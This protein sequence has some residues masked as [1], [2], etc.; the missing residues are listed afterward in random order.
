[1]NVFARLIGL[2]LWAL[3][4]GFIARHKGR[5]FWGWYFLSFLISP[6]LSMIITLFLSN[7]L[8]NSNTEQSC[9]TGA[10]SVSTVRNQFTIAGKCVCN[11]CGEKLLE[12]SAFCHQCG[13]RYVSAKE[14][15]SSREDGV[16]PDK[17]AVDRS[18][19]YAICPHCGTRQLSNRSLCWN[20]GVTFE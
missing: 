16:L 5:S 3:I 9:G 20:C 6:L 11:Q 7:K 2:A 19:E 8:Q 10:A 14:N 4:P 18:Q 13:A 12:G 15:E 17:V 1:M